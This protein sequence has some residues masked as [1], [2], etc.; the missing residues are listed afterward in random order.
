MRCQTTKQPSGA[1]TAA[2]PRLATSA[3]RKNGSNTTCLRAPDLRRVVRR[4]AMRRM[5]HAGEVVA[6]IVMVTIDGEGARRL[7]A[8]QPPVG[9]MLG[10][11]LRHARAA[12]VMVEADD[13]IGA[14]HDDVQIVRDEQHAE[15]GLVAQA[16]DQ[17]VEVRLAHVVDALHRLVEHQEVGLAQQRAGEN[18]ALQLAARQL[19]ELLIAHVAA[20][21][22]PRMSPTR[23]ALSLAAEHQEA[24]DRHRD[25]GVAVEALRHVADA[26]ILAPVHRAAVGLFEPEQHTHQRRLA[27]AVG[28]DQRD[29][30]ALADVEID[31]DEQVTA[32]AGDAETARGDERGRIERRGASSCPC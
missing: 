6:V 9:R 25:D 21:T 17:V 15:A 2:S 7:G 14:R 13:A 29:D 28:T 26:Q 31:I 30:L 4:I 5:R 16:P 19:A 23:S 1:A 20:S 18:D 22:W 27:G 11:R 24:L 12:D 8:E 10:H 32:V 3:R